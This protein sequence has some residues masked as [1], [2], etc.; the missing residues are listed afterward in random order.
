MTGKLAAFLATL[1]YVATGISGVLIVAEPSNLGIEGDTLQVVAG[2]LAL[3]ASVVGVVV[4]A[5]RRNLIPGAETGIG[6][7]G[8]KP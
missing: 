2:W 1:A 5:I 7:E 3:G 8:T 6:N 4:V